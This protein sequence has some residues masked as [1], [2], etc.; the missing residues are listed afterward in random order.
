MLIGISCN[1]LCETLLK[2]NKQRRK[3]V[4]DI[5]RV[6]EKMWSQ[7]RCAAWLADADPLVQKVRIQVVL[8]SISP[9]VFVSH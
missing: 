2:V 1:L 4:D 3:I 5:E 7:G 9:F 6:A 8:F